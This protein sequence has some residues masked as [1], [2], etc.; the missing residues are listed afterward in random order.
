[1]KVIDIFGWMGAALMCAATFQ[2]DTDV[3]KIGAMG[4]LFL[5]S[6]QALDNR[7][8]NLVLLNTVSIGG[9]LYALYF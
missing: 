6:L 2:I 8:Y 4:G 3:G 5:L 1:M 9:F 7:C